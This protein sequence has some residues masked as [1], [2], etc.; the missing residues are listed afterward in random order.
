VRRHFF[1]RLFTAYLLILTVGV[2]AV[3]IFAAGRL[4]ETRYDSEQRTLREKGRLVYAIIEDDLR[5]NRTE[6]IQQKLHPFSDAIGCRLTI[7]A[8]DGRVIADT[9]ADPLEMDNH[10]L[11]PELLQALEHEEGT[12]IRWS[13]TL[14][15]ELMYLANRIDEPNAT[16]FVRLAIPMTVFNKSVHSFD[17][18]LFIAALAMVVV[19]G[20]V[21]W[22]LA[23]S[24]TEPIA[25]LAFSA[26]AMAAGDIERR[27]HPDSAGEVGVLGRALNT[28]AESLSRTI[29]QA[30]KDK[31]ELFTVLA[32]MSDG[33]IATDA[34]Q[35]IFL[36][37]P[38]AGNL[39]NFSI[40]GATGRA[41]WE[42]IHEE[43]ILKAASKAL[44]SPQRV[45][46]QYEPSRGKH[47]EIVVSPLMYQAR[48]DGLL[49]AIRDT[50]QAV[51]YQDLRKEFVAN[52]SHE[53]RTP[54]TFIRG[55]VETLQDGALKDPEKGPQF[56][57]TIE[58]HVGQLSN[59]VDE[60]LELSKMESRPG[61]SRSV[62]VNISDRIR[63]AVELMAP[64]AQKKDHTVNMNLSAELLTVPGDPDYIDRAITNLLDNAIKYTP[65]KGQI[66]LSAY[67][68]DSTAVI[69]VSDNGI[70]IPAAD[71]PRIFERFYRVDKS[72][73]RDMGGT[74]LGLSIVKHIAQAHGGG[75]DVSSEPGKGT[76]FRMTLPKKRSA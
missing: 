27:N 4:R 62:P 72:R 37:N 64:A 2:G 71:I 70:G 40:E 13:H 35:H 11:R 30:A 25:E 65:E 68:V 16:Y 22:F 15:Q 23:L 3:A 19:G 61:L 5:A 42:V 50:T 18:G 41:L 60:L 44:A 21:C 9:L 39:L 55:F 56:L 73:S 53:L 12:S 43:A 66:Q 29:S 33:V 14:Q 28:L 46:L 17:L 75:V 59:L 51:Q 6:I 54:L 47:F 38:A 57:A 45:V 48:L 34:R 76:T 32:S 1:W 10:R 7:V 52:V 36:I 67:S 74:G 26:Q 20:V 49:I 58:K 31:E 24:Q 8:K 69:E 63:K